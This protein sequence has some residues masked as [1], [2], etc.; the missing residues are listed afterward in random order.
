MGWV[1]QGPPQVQAP[2]VAL[3]RQKRRHGRLS[4]ARTW[5][6]R[7]RGTAGSGPQLPAPPQRRWGW[8]C[9]VLPPPLQMRRHLPSG[10]RRTP[11]APACSG[12]S[13]VRRCRR[14]C[15]TGAAARARGVGQDGCARGGAGVEMQTGKMLWL[16]GRGQ[17][18][19]QQQ[20]HP[21]NCTS[22]SLMAAST[23]ASALPPAA[24]TEPAARHASIMAAAHSFI[25]RRHGEAINAACRPSCCLTSRVLCLSAWRVE[26]S[27]RVHCH[28][29]RKRHGR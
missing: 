2:A 25:A 5:V 17:Q 7:A 28:E 18:V 4:S 12:W 23:A 15:P 21:A 3:H 14:G 22:R 29:I 13:H 10:W 6:A 19:Q 16:P 20:D 11:P 24:S 27:A 26:A 8:Q 9:R 1:C